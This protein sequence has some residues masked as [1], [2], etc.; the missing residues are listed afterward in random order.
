[1]N[2]IEICCI[3]LDDLN[4]SKKDNKEIDIN[5]L[6]K[7]NCNH[8]YHLDCIYK[9]IQYK[10]IYW[11][12]IYMETYNCT[13]LNSRDIKNI[14]KYIKCPLCREQIDIN[15]TCELVHQY[16]HKL[17]RLYNIIK[18][19]LLFLHM[20]HVYVCTRYRFANRLHKPD[21]LSKCLDA[22]NK[23]NDLI[24]LKYK[25]KRLMN[26]CTIYNKIK[27]YEYMETIYDIYNL[28]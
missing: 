18:R 25:Y 7:L 26:E 12:D 28:H 24:C 15:I 1:M 19:Q 11:M 4:E 16:Y 14:L 23:F 9:H 8:C 20:Y 21:I 22:E 2:D 6:I 17:K 5:Q 27:H 10:M 13:N 3:C